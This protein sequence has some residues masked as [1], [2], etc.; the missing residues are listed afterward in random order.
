MAGRARDFELLTAAHPDDLQITSELAMV[1]NDQAA[2]LYLTAPEWRIPR[3]PF[4]VP[5]ESRSNSWRKP[6]TTQATA[7]TFALTQRILGPFLAD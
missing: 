5:R 2:Y 1:Y 4:S 7:A 6:L 3:R